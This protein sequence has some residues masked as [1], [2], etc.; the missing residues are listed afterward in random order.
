LSLPVIDRLKSKYGDGVIG[1]AR[2]LDT[3]RDPRRDGP[4][5]SFTYPR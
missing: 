5:I 3:G 4:R 1:S 2:I